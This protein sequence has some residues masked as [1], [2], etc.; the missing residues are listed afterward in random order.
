MENIILNIAEEQLHNCKC[1]DR[2]FENHKWFFDELFNTFMKNSEV[3]SEL[4]LQASKLNIEETVYKINIIKEKINNIYSYMH[5]QLIFKNLPKFILFIGGENS[6]DAHGMI[7]NNEPYVFINITMVIPRL[8]IKEFDM[9]LF[10]VHEMIHA[11]HYNCS[12][13]FYL[14]NYI[15]LEDKYLKKLISEGMATFMSSKILNKKLEKAFWI[16]FITDYEVTEWVKNAEDLVGNIGEKLK[17]SLEENKFNNELFSQLFYVKNL[18]T[19]SSYRLGYYYGAK[20]IE[21]LGGNYDLLKASYNE[22]STKT[23]EYFNIKNT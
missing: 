2:V 23:L 22:Y 20:I 11:I 9:E 18:E 4:T 14:G 8:E 17:V 7:I 19:L 6:W 15:T 3:K 21:K 1:M 16:G 10:I 12:P 13:E 5:K